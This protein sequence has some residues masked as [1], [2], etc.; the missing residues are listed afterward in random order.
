MDGKK[1]LVFLGDHHGKWEQVKC[2]IM[3]NQM[4]NCHL[5]CVGDGGEGFLPKDRQ[6]RQFENLNDF[7]KAR[8]I[9]YK[10]IRGNHS[11]PFYFLKEN[12]N[13]LSHFE[14]LEDYSILE[15]NGKTIQFIGG[16]ISL[17]RTG[18][19]DGISYWSDE[20]VKY[21]PDLLKEVDILVTHTTPSYCFPRGFNEM[22]YS[23]AREDAYLIEDLT[24]E[25]IVMDEILKVCKP[26]HHFY[27]HFHSSCMEEINGCKHRL[28]DINEFFELIL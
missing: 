9:E 16:A 15:Y 22:V 26:K 17:D 21:K 18:R 13:P 25:R 12:I 20:A 7:F 2:L 4:D 24:D 11:D 14:L 23:W 10:T 27:G 8:N 28:L 1:P 19:R 3:K 6:M 5:I